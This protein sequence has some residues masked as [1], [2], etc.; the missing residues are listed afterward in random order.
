VERADETGLDESE[1]IE[2]RGI[3]VAVLVSFLALLAGVFGSIYSDD[4]KR[5]TPFCFFNNWTVS[6]CCGG[7]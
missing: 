3:T 1:R 6:G 7:V 2:W 4:I 5:A